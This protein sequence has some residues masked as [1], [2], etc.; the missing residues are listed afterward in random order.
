MST[1]A[2]ARMSRSIE[3]RNCAA[4]VDVGPPRCASKCVNVASISSF[5]RARTSGSSC[6]SDIPH[7]F[8]LASTEVL[9][10]RSSDRLQNGDDLPVIYG[11]GK[12]HRDHDQVRLD[13]PHKELWR[14]HVL[15]LQITPQCRD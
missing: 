7:P 2:A 9:C 13:S 11:R 6:G 5:N 12:T 14:G 15:L 1:R 8:C 4:V 10:E 3:C